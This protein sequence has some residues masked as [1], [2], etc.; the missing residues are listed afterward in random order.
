MSR[1]SAQIT[2]KWRR[3]WG[4]QR[5]VSLLGKWSLKLGLGINQV[6]YRD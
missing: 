2:S 3:Q 4:W 5:L 1:E 6:N